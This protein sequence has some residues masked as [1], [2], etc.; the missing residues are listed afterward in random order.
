MQ[1]LVSLQAAGRLDRF[2]GSREWTV[3][4]FEVR[5]G[6]P[7]DVGV[8]GEA[9]TDGLRIVFT[10]RPGALT[11]RLP[12]SAGLSPAAKAVHVTSPSTLAEL[13]RLIMG[14]RP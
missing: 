14:R 1:K 2:D 6:G 3:E 12:K 10:A 5:S 13:G 4:R 8:D 9:L 7:V 11:V